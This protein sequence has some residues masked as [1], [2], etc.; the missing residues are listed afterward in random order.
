MACPLLALRGHLLQG[1]QRVDA[2]ILSGPG[3]RREQ[4]VHGDTEKKGKRS[5]CVAVTLTFLLASR[6]KQRDTVTFMDSGKITRQ[7]RRGGTEGHPM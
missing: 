4:A 3:R 5:F 2:S 6:S 1:N 7:S